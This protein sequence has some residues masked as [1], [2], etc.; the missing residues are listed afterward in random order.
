VRLSSPL[1]TAKSYGNGG[2][3]PWSNWR[4]WCENLSTEVAA[5]YLSNT[6]DVLEAK[7]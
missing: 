5:N 1:P 7:G 6:T 3:P 4:R 2:L